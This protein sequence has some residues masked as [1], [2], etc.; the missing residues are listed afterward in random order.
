MHNSKSTGTSKEAKTGQIIPIEQDQ[1]NRH[2][3]AVNA[4]DHATH[5]RSGCFP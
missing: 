3:E 5:A 4:R 1:L 2:I